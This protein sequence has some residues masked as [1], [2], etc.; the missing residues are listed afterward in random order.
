[1]T[2]LGCLFAIIVIILAIFALICGV[3]VELF[4]PVAA[5]VAAYYIIRWLKNQSSEGNKNH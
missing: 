2:I 3:V 5:I 4:W 1:M